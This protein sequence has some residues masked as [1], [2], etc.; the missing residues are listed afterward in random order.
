MQ[1]QPLCLL[2][3]LA[4]QAVFSQT[5]ITNI[6]PPSNLLAPGSTTVSISFDTARPA[7]CAY[8]VGSQLPF[9][10]MTPLTGGQK[11][12]SHQGTVAGLSPSP[13]VL[14]TVYLECD[15]DPAFTQTLQ[16]RAATARNGAF[17]RIGNIW[18]G[19]Y[20][21]NTAPN[22]AAQT[23][24]FFGPGGITASQ[25]VALRAQEPSVLILPSVNAQETTGGTP[26]VPNSYLLKD[27]NGNPIEDW[28]GNFLLNLTLPEVATF[29]AQYAFEQYF[30]NANLAFDGIFWDNFH[31][32]IPNVY[33][34]YLG[35]AH[36]VDANGDGIPDDQVTLNAAWSQG[37]YTLI[38]DFDSLAPNAYVAG[39]I[40]QVPPSPDV[41]AAFNGES[42][43][44]NALQ[45]REG[46]FSFDTLLG[47]YNQWMA[48][49]RQPAIATVQS[50]P[51]SQIAYG[52]GYRQL[53]NMLPSTVQ[54][55]QSFYPNMRFG[56]ALALLNDG[57]SIYD[58]GDIAQP[59]TWW[60]DEYNFN[61]GAALAPARQVGV[62][63]AVS[64]LSNGGFESGLSSWS[65]NVYN[66]G[67]ASATAAID[68]SISAAGA[69]SAMIHVAMPGTM[70]WHVGFEQ[71][72]LPLTAGAGYRVQFWARSDAPRSI[73]VFS[74]GGAPNYP[75][76]GLSQAVSLT[77]SW[78]FFSVSFT[79]P[80]TANDGRLEFW[81]GDQADSVWLDN[82]AL[83]PMGVDTY[84]R[85]Y[86][87]GAVLLNGAASAQ[88]IAVEAGFK[89]FSGRQAPLWQYIVDDAAPNFTADSSWQAVTYDT[90]LT[91]YNFG[92]APP[93]PNPSFYHAWNF[94][95]HR[96]S[97]PGS[98]A[99]WNLNIPADGQ[100]T[101]QVW[102]PAAP[103]AANWTKSAVYEIVSNGAVVATSTLDQTT[104]AAGDAWHTVGTVQLTAAGSPILRVHNSGSSPLLADAVYITSAALF[105]DGSPVS[106]V[107]LAPY[108]GI[109]LKRQQPVAAPASRV[110]SV[111]NAA[112]FQP[113]ISAGAFVSI[114][115]TGFTAGATVTIDAKPAQVIYV[116]PT[117][118]NVVA[119][120]DTAIGQ[121]AV[122]VTTP[123]GAAYPG[124]VLK[125]KLSPAFFTYG[126]GTISYAA[127]VH[128]DGT[129]V[130]PTGPSS[131]PALPGEVIEVYG[132]GF[133][134]NPTVT[135]GRVAA[136]VQF[137]GLASP[138]L[139]QMNVKI[140]K[141]PTGDQ[142]IAAGVSGFQ[143]PSPV[144]VSVQSN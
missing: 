3:I 105:N 88:T 92:V 118:I 127:A 47:M 142:P 2:S 124:T 56:L 126:V 14:N 51:P 107:A 121:V 29:L 27:V 85:D 76:Y 20:T 65:L 52:Y 15:S 101:I 23:Q 66:D 77:P 119:P 103:E 58:F 38:D 113:A 93:N 137:A 67:Q 109:L 75:D 79:A 6:N 72:G 42:F 48:G 53:Q 5:P 78:Q 86:T 70:P 141:L 94:Q 34:D 39:H 83:I 133:G 13:L 26:A 114:L 43:T 125:Q 111:V 69:S 139:Y 61:L 123:Q 74:Q 89:R 37:M 90:G 98:A 71:D 120:A 97:T 64:L 32:T 95:A 129:L 8:S 81:V 136:E 19:D 21:L 33:Y 4:L 110:S 50:S 68:T 99:A 28:P 44:F 82:V 25:A 73:T 7:S 17:P 1:L 60:Y 108:D 130:G 41:L 122:Q 54:F 31:T 144:F 10:S 135:V 106:A 59:V 30:T 22:Q 63:P 36:Q 9:A 91:D 134:P 138:G 12:T 49:G 18:I 11:T 100:Y 46:A 143:T 55:A 112:G 16:Y 131:R 102:L 116:S 80:V 45:V 40:G 84:R 117:Q 57:F 87:N 62:S 115:G 132:T 104:A 128:V 96:Q 24:I 140:P 35:V